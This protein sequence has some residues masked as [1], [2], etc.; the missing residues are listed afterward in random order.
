[1]KTGNKRSSQCFGTLAK[2]H[3]ACL[4]SN[5]HKLIHTQNL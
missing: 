1:M 2:M 3:L 4:R 5:K